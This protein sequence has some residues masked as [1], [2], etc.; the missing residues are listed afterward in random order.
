M[1]EHWGFPVEGILR[2]ERL[3]G[4]QHYDVARLAIQRSDWHEKLIEATEA[5]PSYGMPHMRRMLQM[6]GMFFPNTNAPQNL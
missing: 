2:E 6:N 5:T 4:Q 1:A 3:L